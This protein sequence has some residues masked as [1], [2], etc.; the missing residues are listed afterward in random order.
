MSIG[1]PYGA[2][3]TDP[4]RWERISR[5]SPEEAQAQLAGELYGEGGYLGGTAGAEYGTS[6]AVGKEAYTS[7]LS[8]QR[9]ALTYGGL[10]GSQSLLSGTSGAV[11]RS[12]A[13]IMQAEDVLSEAYKKSKTLGAEFMEA[14][15]ITQMSL[16]ENL[17]TAGLARTMGRGRNLLGAGGRST[18]MG[19]G[20]GRMRR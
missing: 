5:M 8:A 1:D 17:N 16:E 20:S 15:E 4:F 13:G 6:T 2:F 12:G 7:G 10:T 19:T 18:T 14:G 3:A 9:E 11:L